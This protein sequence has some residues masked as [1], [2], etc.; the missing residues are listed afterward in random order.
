MG[1]PRPALVSYFNPDLISYLFCF[2]AVLDVEGGRSGNNGK[3]SERDL[4]PK[5]EDVAEIPPKYDEATMKP[6]EL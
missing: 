1:L 4:P 3:H 6:N 5:Y 2:K